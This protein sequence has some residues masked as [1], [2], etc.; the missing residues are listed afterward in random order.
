MISLMHFRK[1]FLR[2]YF[3]C[4]TEKRKDDDPCFLTD[5]PLL[6]RSDIAVFDPLFVDSYDEIL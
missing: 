6:E 1:S 3:D 2:I 4:I 5:K